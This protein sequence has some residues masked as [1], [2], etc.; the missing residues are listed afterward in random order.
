MNNTNTIRKLTIRIFEVTQKIQEKFPELYLLLSET[1]L[2]SSEGKK[3]ISVSDLGKYLNTLKK[4]LW[5]F[6]KKR[7]GKMLK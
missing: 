1:P 7:K 4:Q 2:F 6:E 5:M 3:P